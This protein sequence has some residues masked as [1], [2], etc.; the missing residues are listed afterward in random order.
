MTDYYK[1]IPL[2]VLTRILCRKCMSDLSEAIHTGKGFQP[3]LACI[4][5]A[6]KWKRESEK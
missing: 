3:C 2:N 6:A 4:G 5:S 1:K